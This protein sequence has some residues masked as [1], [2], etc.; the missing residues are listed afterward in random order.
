MS[1]VSVLALA[2][3]LAMDAT[4][5]AAVCG[6]ATPVLRARHF[7]LVAVYFGAAQGLMPLLGWLLAAWLGPEVAAWDHWIAFVLLSGIGAKMIW[8]AWRG[9]EGGRREGDVFAPKVM[10]GLAIATSIDAAA[11]GLTLP[12]F[13][14]PIAVSVA[15]IGV[16]T[17]VLSM[18][19]LAIGRRVG[20][21]IGRGLD[22]FGG[23]VL[24]ALGVK[25]LVEHLSAGA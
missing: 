11:A 9:E 25:V 10:L 14:V 8:E 16:T 3:G 2:L 5:A 18:I 17:A 22:T 15:T 13:E 12:M 19:G 1:F 4:A 21:R 23:A 24:I 20:A 7:A 6:V